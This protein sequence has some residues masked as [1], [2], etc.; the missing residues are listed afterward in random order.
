MQFCK[1]MNHR[2]VSANSSKTYYVEKKKK[3]EESRHSEYRQYI[4]FFKVYDDAV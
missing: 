2:I 1:L 4:V 3:E